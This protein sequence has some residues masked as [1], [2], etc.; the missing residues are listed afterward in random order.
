MKKHLLLVAVL[1]LILSFSVVSF[2]EPDRPTITLQVFVDPNCKSN[3]TYVA[4]LTPVPNDPNTIVKIDFYTGD[5]IT[6][7][8]P[9]KYVGSA[10][11]D[12]TGVAKIQFWQIPGEYAGGAIWVSSVYGKIFSNVMIY[13]VPPLP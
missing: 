8:F 7:V 10:P 4:K 9:T 6:T 11:I 3:V 13:N 12:S 5:P 2:T 1:A